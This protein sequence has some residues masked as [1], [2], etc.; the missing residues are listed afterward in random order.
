ML[1]AGALLAGAAGCEARSPERIARRLEVARPDSGYRWDMGT[2]RDWI[3]MRDLSSP[4][5]R[6]DEARLARFAVVVRLLATP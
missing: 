5:F 2:T 3:G 4:H 6:P 1:R